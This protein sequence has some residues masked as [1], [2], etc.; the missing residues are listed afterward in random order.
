[1]TE[2]STEGPGDRVFDSGNDD[3]ETYVLDF[4]LIYAINFSYVVL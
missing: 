3:D 4:I 2:S 1:M